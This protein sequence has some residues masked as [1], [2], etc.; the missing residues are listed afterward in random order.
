MAYDTPRVPLDLVNLIDS[1]PLV[2]ALQFDNEATQLCLVVVLG[3]DV[4]E[5]QGEAT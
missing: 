5:K 3:Y 2:G 1:Q 4:A